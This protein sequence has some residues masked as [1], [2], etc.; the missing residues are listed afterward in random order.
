M[1]NAKI[2]TYT[3]IVYNQV[4]LPIKFQHEVDIN[5]AYIL[6]HSLSTQNVC[7]HIPILARHTYMTRLVKTYHLHTRGT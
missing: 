3:A 4:C 5:T 2:C 7:M 6:V 1:H